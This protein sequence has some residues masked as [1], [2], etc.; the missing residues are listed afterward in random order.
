MKKYTTVAK[1]IEIM[2]AMCGIGFPCKLLVYNSNVEPNRLNENDFEVIIDVHDVATHFGNY[3]VWMVMVDAYG[4]GG[5]PCVELCICK[6]RPDAE[7]YEEYMAKED[8]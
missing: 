6:Q 2:K 4:S 1:W 7:N 5:R 3:F 8:N